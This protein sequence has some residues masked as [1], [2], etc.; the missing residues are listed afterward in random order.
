[1]EQRHQRDM[2]VCSALDLRQ[3][4]TV[5]G[6]VL[7]KV[8]VYRYLG[9]LILQD[10]NDIQAIRS[11]LCKAR[12][13]WHGLDKCCTRKMHP[14]GLAPSSTRQPSNLSSCME[15]RLLS[16]AVMTRFEGFHIHAAHWMAKEHIPYQGPHRQ[17]MYPPSNKV[18]EECGML[19]IQ[20]YIDVQ[21]QTIARYIVDCSIF[22]E[23][24]GTDQRHGLVPRWWWWE[25]QMCLEYV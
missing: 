22:A 25:Q 10:D 16:K 15:A 18:L 9:R 3:Q 20:H 2:A 12:G 13:T 5:H 8:K 1:M 23:C 21:R 19:T 14:I 7:E 24:K 4:F 6:D 17:W 11:Q